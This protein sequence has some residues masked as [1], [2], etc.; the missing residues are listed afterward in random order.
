[1]ENTSLEGVLAIK[2][3][4]TLTAIIYNDVKRRAQVIYSVK[5]MGVDEIQELFRNGFEN[6]TKRDII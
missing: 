4:G 2:R 1:M 5:E 6:P 3:N